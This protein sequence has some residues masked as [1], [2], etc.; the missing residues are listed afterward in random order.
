MA[1][2]TGASEA[3]FDTGDRKVYILLRWRLSMAERRG[4]VFAMVHAAGSSEADDAQLMG[5]IARGD[6]LA[7]QVLYARY[8]LRIYRFLLRLT[9]NDAAA[10]DILSDVFLDVWKQAARFEARS[11]VATWLCAMARNKAYAAHR[12]QRSTNLE[13]DKAELIADDADTPEVAV[14]KS[15]KSR[16]LEECIAGLSPEHREVIDLV[17]YHEMSVADVSRVLD[18]PENTVKTR[19]FYARKRLSVLLLSAGVDRGWP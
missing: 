3:P 16:A 17:Y 2:A 12:K 14:E 15:D 6:A 1:A 13:D 8:N 11:S 7:M 19:M 5:R 9:G 18:V 10:E 4:T